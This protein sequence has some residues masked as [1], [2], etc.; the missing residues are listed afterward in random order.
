VA[1]GEWQSVEEASDG[2]VI[3]EARPMRLT[4]LAGECAWQNSEFVAVR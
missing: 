1:S 3:H 2:V 4:N